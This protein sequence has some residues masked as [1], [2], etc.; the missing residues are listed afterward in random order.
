MLQLFSV[1][2]PLVVMQ[3]VASS[4][5]RLFMPHLLW[6]PI[7]LSIILV[8]S[9]MW[10]HAATPSD[11]HLHN[12]C[13]GLWEH[14]AVSATKRVMVILLP[15]MLVTY[16][17][18]FM[19]GRG[20]LPCTSTPGFA[21]GTL[22]PKPSLIGHR[23]CGLDAP[24]NSLIAFQHAVA[25]PNL[26]GIETDVQWSRDGVGFLMHDP[27]LVRTTDLLSQCHTFK[28]RRNASLFYFH[29]GSCPLHSLKVGR[30]FVQ[31]KKKAL[32]LDR[33][34]AFSSQP[35]PTFRE[36]LEVAKS[37]EKS[38]IFDVS[39]PPHGHPHHKTYLNLTLEDIQ[40]SG[41]PHNK[42]MVISF[43]LI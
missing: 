35:I 16:L 3:H 5:S 1:A 31:L 19:M 32:S 33:Q 6:L 11:N 4:L 42:V 14:T 10:R 24:A 29:N 22:P 36:F 30:E 8:Y 43:F 18:H 7:C 26:I 12:G 20:C 37:A 27:F 13:W 21:H 2:L 38:V 15:S 40:A 17:T 25:I 23:G 28:P 34:V 41:I 9:C 39:E